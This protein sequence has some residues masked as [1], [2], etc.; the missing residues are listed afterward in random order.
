MTIFLFR[1]RNPTGTFRVSHHCKL[2]NLPFA[3]DAIINFALP[4]GTRLFVAHPQKSSCGVMSA[5]T[6]NVLQ[7]SAITQ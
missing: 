5:V 4:G 1:L 6:P 3:Y 7:N 2:S